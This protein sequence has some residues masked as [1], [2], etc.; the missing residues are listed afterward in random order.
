MSKILDAGLLRRD[1]LGLIL[2]RLPFALYSVFPI[3]KS[4]DLIL[5]QPIFCYGDN[6]RLILPFVSSFPAFLSHQ[7]LA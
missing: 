1:I 6:E 3:R 7:V 2:L 4:A 5:G